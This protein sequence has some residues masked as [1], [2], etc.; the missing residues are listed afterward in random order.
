VKAL[1][2]AQRACELTNYEQASSLDTLGVC[3]AACGQFDEAIRYVE[4]ATQRCTG[5]EYA[6][7]E[8]H[9]ELFRAGKAYCE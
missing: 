2:L 4:L 7:C 9:L 8:K 3:H 5:A 6:T 1:Q